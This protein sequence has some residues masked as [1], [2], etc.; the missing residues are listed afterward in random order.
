VCPVRRR[1]RT[2]VVEPPAR[3]VAYDAAEWL[4]LVD[5]TGYDEE[6]FRNYGPMG[7]YGEPFFAFE[8]WL[9]GEAFGLW[10]RARH[11]WCDRFGWPGDLTVLDLLRQEVHMKCGRAD[12]R[13]D[14]GR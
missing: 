7:P 10:T 8:D 11:D 12:S 4:P 9:S 5:R 2:E 3:L 14:D 13:S 6:R 1:A